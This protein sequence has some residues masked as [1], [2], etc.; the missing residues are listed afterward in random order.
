M[1]DPVQQAIG[2]SFDA[3]SR[4]LKIKP[5]DLKF[6]KFDLISPGRMAEVN[7]SRS[8]FASRKQRLLTSQ[9]SG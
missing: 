9:K 6:R 2:R 3:Y 5:I 4:H 7:I 1:P 8:L